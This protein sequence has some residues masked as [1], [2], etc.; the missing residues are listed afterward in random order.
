MGTTLPPLPKQLFDAASFAAELNSADNAIECC[1]S[2]IS[3]AT[4]YQHQRF[5]EGT[6]ANELIR[7]RAAFIDILL[8]ILWDRR[9]W[10]E[11]ELA[12]VAVGGLARSDHACFQFLDSGDVAPGQ[13]V[14]TDLRDALSIRWFGNSMFG[15]PARQGRVAAEEAEF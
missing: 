15:Q 13:V 10:G 5:R 6:Q 11:S 12:L 4:A 3:A 9:D 14:A 1:K 7:Q 8:G 2:A